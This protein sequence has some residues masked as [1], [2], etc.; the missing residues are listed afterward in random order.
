MSFY[1]KRGLKIK[2][3]PRGIE[4]DED[5]WLKPYIAKN[6][7]KRKRRRVSRKRTSLNL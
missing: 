4:F 1:L 7:D 5:D 2:K 6:T 3:I